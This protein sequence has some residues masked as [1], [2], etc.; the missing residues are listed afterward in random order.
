MKLLKYTFLCSILLAM[1]CKEE[2][3]ETT[4]MPEEI[5]T[6]ITT[7]TLES[8][9]KTEATLTTSEAVRFDANKN[10]IY[11][12]NIGAVPPNEKDGDGTLS[13]IDTDGKVLNQNWVTGLN[14]PKGIAIY[15]GKLYVADIDEVVKVDIETGKI[16]KRFIIEG[17]LFLNDVDVDANGTVYVSDTYGNK[18]H[19]IT[20]DEV[21]V[22]K[23]FT[24]FNPNGVL[25]ENNRIVTVSY[26]NGNLIAIDKETKAE[27]LLAIGL[28]GGDGIVSMA[29]GYLVSNWAGEIYYAANNL[30]GE[31]ATLILDTKEAKINAADIAII[32]ERNVLL[33]PTFFAN[34]VA[35]YKI[36]M[37]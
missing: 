17:A 28:N 20:N 3:K 36:N 27:T 21:S 10:V 34:T 12:S 4:V 15:N 37:K 5:E 13:I 24:D 18:I 31:A 35:A 29:D 32:P 11:V 6:T 1:S 14:A 22:W 16:E 23:T 7:V 9:W 2:Q 26:S 8:L 33:V 30:N 19:S 25:V